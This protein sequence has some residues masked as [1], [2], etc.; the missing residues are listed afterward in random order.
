MV[1]KHGGEFDEPFYRNII[2][3]NVH[4]FLHI[5]S[6]F[7]DAFNLKRR[8]KTHTSA[9]LDDEESMLLRE[10]KDSQLC[11]FRSTRSLGHAA[12][13]ALSQGFEY[14]QSGNMATYLRKSTEYADVMGDMIALIAGNNPTSD[15]SAA[16]NPTPVPPTPDADAS[17]DSESSDSES[18]SST[19]INSEDQPPEEESEIERDDA[20]SGSYHT[21]VTDE[22]GRMWMVTLDV[23]SDEEPDLESESDSES[24]SNRDGSDSDGE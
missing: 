13:P 4:H 19:S 9:D 1:K 20:T 21:T 3:P 24:D 22:H 23:A 11:K 8:A 6:E 5:K 16:S 7:E 14:L 12:V 2:S 10:H 17:S 18:N 15:D